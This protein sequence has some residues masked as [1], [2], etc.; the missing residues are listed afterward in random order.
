MDQLP[1]ALW[2][3]AAGQLMD[4]ILLLFK[5]FQFMAPRS[6]ELLQFCE[7]EAAKLGET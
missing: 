3:A 2:A 1:F 6:T 4:E 7:P 5:P